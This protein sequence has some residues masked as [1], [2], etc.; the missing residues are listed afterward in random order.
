METLLTSYFLMALVAFGFGLTVFLNDSTTP[1]SDRTSWIV[2]VVASVCWP[3]IVPIS[4]IKLTILKGRIKLPVVA[5]IASFLAVVVTMQFNNVQAQ[6]TKLQFVQPA[7]VAQHTKDKNIRIL[8]VRVNP[9]DYIVGHLPNAVHIAES[10]FRGP[11]GQL[12]I[13]YWKTDKLQSLFS[14]AGIN[15]D[16]QVIIYSDGTNLLG[17]SM[18][19]YL[20]ERSGHSQAAILD[21]GYSAYKKAELPLTRE[22]PNYNTGRFTVQDQPSVRVTLDQ[23]RQFIGNPDITFIDPRPPAQFSGEEDLFVR[24]GHIP[25]AKNIP[26]VSF[27]LGEEGAYSLKPL[28]QI[29]QILQSKGVS[30]DDDI[31]VT[32]STGREA[33]L[34]YIVLKHLLGYPKVRVYEGSWTEYSAQLDLPVETGHGA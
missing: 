13:Q 22:F 28:D 29:K 3:I 21:G 31:I 27:T 30:R 26:W 32:C 8:D 17:A 5:C 15:N 1:I 24:N 16:T 33:T 14:E 34:Q 10:A 7:W 18:V 12:P 9:F 19:A 4:I 20:L 23:V 2:L 11:N 25:G 6:S